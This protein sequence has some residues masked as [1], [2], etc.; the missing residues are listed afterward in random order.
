MPGFNIA[1]FNAVMDA[2][3]IQKTNK[4]RVLVPIPVGLQQ[5]PD[6]N[7]L[8][9]TS[10]YMEYFIDSCQIPAVIMG[11]H[12][13]LRYGYGAF[14]KKPVSPSFEDFPMTV[15]GDGV[16]GIHNFLVSWMLMISNFDMS[17]GIAPARNSRMVSGNDMRPFDLS[18]KYEYMTDVTVI[19]YNDAG[20]ETINITLR[21]AWP[22][23]LG[24]LPMNW[25][26]GTVARF[27][28]VMTYQ[29]WHPNAL[30]VDQ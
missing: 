4:A 27:P 21:E 2:N 11:T 9:V 19:A 30:N 8:A 12:V 29:D 20:I 28:L 23:M 16:G 15:I 7:Q 13:N 22:V 5:H 18:Y 3:G 6:Y 10:Q 26:E 25:S 17:K 1:S 14:E 24:Q